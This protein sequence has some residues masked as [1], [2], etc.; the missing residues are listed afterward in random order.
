MVRH[1]KTVELIK[2]A[3]S[4]LEER[5]PMTVPDEVLQARIVEEVETRLDLNVLADVRVTEEAERAQLELALEA[6]QV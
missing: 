4:I 5:H 1:A 6:V 3:R 2:A